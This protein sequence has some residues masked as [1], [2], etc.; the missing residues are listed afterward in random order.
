MHR[1]RFYGIALGTLVSFATRGFAQSTVP[2]SLTRRVDSVFSRY[3]ASTPGC[4]L[5]VYQNGRVAYSKGYGLASVEFGVPITPRTPFITGSLSKQFTAAAIALLVEQGR[6]SLNDDVRKYVP[7]LHD[8]G[9]R[10]TID[11]LVHHTSGIRDWWALVDVAG[12]RP[13]DG[14][15]VD[16][17]LALAAKQR[18]L[19]FDPGAEYN[20]SNTGYVLLGAVV[21]RV[22]GKTLRQ[23]AAEQ[24]FTPL[25]MPI[26]HFHDNHNE[27][28]RGRASAYSPLSGGAW[29]INVWNNDIVGQGGVMTTIEELQKWDENFYT[30]AVGG[31]GF[32]ARQLQRGKLNNDSTIAYAFGLEIGSYRGLPMVDHSG[33]TGGYRT[34]LVRFPSLH[35][36]VA[37]LC[38]VSTADAVGFA[39]R[40]ADIVIA[41]KFTQP[42]PI[43]GTRAAT[44]QGMATVALTQAELSA[45]AGRYYSDELNATYELAQVG[46][47]LVLHRPRA[48]A[49][50]LRATDHQT[51]RGSGLTIRFARPVSGGPAA[52]FSVDN[53]RARGLEFNR[54]R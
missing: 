34:D 45:M 27:P 22:T 10:V 30:G 51:L 7:E 50:T 12:M 32:L 9:K 39:R 6:I 42:V 48:A 35:T 2:D 36:S 53:G 23:F 25:G 18:H 49:D 43:A 33:S 19:N 46:S 11:H 15:T 14:Y 24:I 41:D 29:T 40:V 31:K 52:N 44:Q 3:N 20:Y 4:A 16:D 17:V 28:V 1:H 37:T 38:N 5:G 13:D 8:Y 21:K 54:E 47:A 26:S